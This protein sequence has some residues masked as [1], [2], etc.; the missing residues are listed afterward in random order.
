MLLA[1]LPEELQEL[2]NRVCTAGFVCNLRINVKKT[3][4]MTMDGSVIDITAD[5]VPLTQ[6]SEFTYLGATITLESSCAQDM[7]TRLQ[8]ALGVMSGAQKLWK[9]RT[10]SLQT[11][12]RLLK[13]L[14]WPVPTYGCESWTLQKPDQWKIYAFELKT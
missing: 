5:G 10:I 4:V 8:K 1:S 14:V 6:V 3:Q 11:K 2:V 7:Q 12:L 13:A 9:S